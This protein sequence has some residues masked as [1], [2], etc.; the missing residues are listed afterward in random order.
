MF[1]KRAAFSLS[2]G[3]GVYPTFRTAIIEPEPVSKNCD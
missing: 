1:D 3:G 2:K